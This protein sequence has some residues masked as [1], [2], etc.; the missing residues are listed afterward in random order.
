MTDH[1]LRMSEYEHFQSTLSVCATSLSVFHI[2]FFFFNCQLMLF[3]LCTHSLQLCVELMAVCLYLE[4]YFIYTLYS[5]VWKYH[6]HCLTKCSWNMSYISIYK[7]PPY[8][9]IIWGRDSHLKWCR[10]EVDV[11]EVHSLN[12]IMHSNNDFTTDVHSMASE[13]P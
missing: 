13:Y 3:L 11:M 7:S 5:T 1:F 2:S 8:P 9:Y 4:V 6:L 10:T 12:P